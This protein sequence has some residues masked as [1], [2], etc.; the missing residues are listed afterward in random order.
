[1]LRFKG[2]VGPA[3]RS[4]MAID[5]VS[6]IDNNPPNCPPVE[7]VDQV[8]IPDGE[9]GAEIV[10]S[11]GQVAVNGMVDFKAL[12]EVNL[13]SGFEVLQ[14]GVFEV[15]MGNCNSTNAQDE[16]EEDK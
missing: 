4:D 1:M 13:N 11:S 14:G 15:I 8:P 3:F 7:N 12:I 9:Y 5:N 10:N 16:L 6:M 2:S